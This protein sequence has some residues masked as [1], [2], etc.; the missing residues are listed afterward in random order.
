MNVIFLIKCVIL[1][2]VQGLTEPLP[3]SSSGHVVIIGNLIG[4][5]DLVDEIDFSILLNFG[6][7]IA[8][9]IIFR[10]EIIDLIVWTFKYIFK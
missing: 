8:I 7:L 9:L 5:N 3:I 2:I 10:K 6:S 4:A 1:G